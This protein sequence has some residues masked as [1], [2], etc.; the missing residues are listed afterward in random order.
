MAPLPEQLPPLSRMMLEAHTRGF[1]LGNA[2]SGIA[3]YV[4]YDPQCH[5]CAALWRACQPLVEQVKFVWIPLAFLNRASF[6]Q[7]ATILAAADPVAAMTEHEARFSN[8]QAGI[9]ADKAAQ[10]THGPF[11]KANTEVARRLKIESVPTTY[12]SRPGRALV[13]QKGALDT[14]ALRTALGL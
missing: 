1:V 13:M 12:I 2:K 5:Y 9:T 8:K 6:S 14:G 3:A 11:I 4:F 7:G 10:K